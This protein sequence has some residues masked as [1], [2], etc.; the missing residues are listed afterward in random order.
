MNTLTRSRTGAWALAAS[1]A[2]SLLAAC[3]GGGGS[4]PGSPPPITGNPPA[5]LSLSAHGS[6]A[7]TTSLAWSPAP[8]ASGYTLER[9]TAGSAWA[10]I[11]T[12]GAEDS[13]Y[14]DDG[15]AQAT[16]YSY[17][18]SALGAPAAPAEHA[19]TTTASAP[20]I[21]AA[22]AALPA[23]P[24]TGEIG[25][26]GGSVANAEGSVRLALPAGAVTARTAVSLQATS[27]PL[28]DGDGP[29]VQVRLA[30]RPK[31]PLLLTMRYEAGM[32]PHA[33]GMAVAVH[34]A[35]GSWLSLPVT[36]L[37]TAAR[38]LSVAIAPALVAPAAATTA[39]AGLQFHVVR[40]LNLRL[41]P[42]HA[43]LE[44]GQ[45][46]LFVPY[47]RTEVQ[48]C[49]DDAELGCLPALVVEPREI[50][51]LNQ[52][53]GYQRQWF[54]FAE[55][56]GTAALGTVT[57]RASSGAVYRA[58]Q[59]TPTPNPVLVS[60]QSRHLKSGRTVTLSAAVT[61]EEPV[62]T[63]VLSGVL[64]QAD[65]IGFSY[66]AQAVW[67]REQGSGGT[68]ETYRASG[69]QSVH[70][71]N[72]VCTASPTPATVP[73]PPGALTI[74]R[75]VEPARYRLDVGSLWDTAISGTCPGGGFANVPLRVPGQLIVE[76]TVSGN[77]TKIEGTTSQNH[78]TWNW[79]LS[80][81]L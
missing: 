71:I 36:A 56:G 29:G 43:S 18:L 23:A 35:D 72:I 81:Q 8:G 75:S 48:P 76:G 46:Q 39:T 17:K 61:V 38:T 44:T 37:D 20:L 30:A 34:R 32:A 80:N 62:W 65:D 77:G 66:S 78:I 63:M 15:L 42:R 47:A 64:Q 73:L 57:P 45:T 16:T 25:A 55:A 68:L 40:Y 51:L 7:R 50:P 13:A 33:D 4:E 1:A 10:V 60:F 6:S 12:L 79:S 26:A 9:R 67:T 69:T 22:P 31:Q 59:H 27:N 24:D 41:S 3:G 21:T 52:K 11:A 54:V 74:D 2:L 70:V 5:A 28:P 14:L 19:A 49:W 53:A 58:P